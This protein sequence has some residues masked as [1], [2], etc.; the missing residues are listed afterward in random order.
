DAKRPLDRKPVDLL[1]L[2]GDAVHN[3]QAMAA[4]QQTDPQRRITLE[5]RP[6]VG[7]MDVTGDEARLRQVLA[8]L[9]GN[10]LDHTPASAAITVRLTP[11]ADAVRID[12]ID[13]GPGL[14]PEAAA[15]V[16]ERFYRTDD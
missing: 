5:V 15:R 16:F 14:P 6:G 9:L 4:Q 10:A 13:T 7:T 1:A 11:S 2:A 12:V 8:N 3:A